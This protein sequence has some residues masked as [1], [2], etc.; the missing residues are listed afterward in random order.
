MS[1]RNKE[2][3]ITGKNLYNQTVITFFKKNIF[4]YYTSTQFKHIATKK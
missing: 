4:N 2:Y 1:G 3:S